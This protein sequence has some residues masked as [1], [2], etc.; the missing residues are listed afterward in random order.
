MT[1]KTDITEK[2]YGRLTV[3]KFSHKDNE[4][5]NTTLAVRFNLSEL[6]KKLFGFELE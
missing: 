5:N 2:R 3:I 1:V 6:Q 4:Y